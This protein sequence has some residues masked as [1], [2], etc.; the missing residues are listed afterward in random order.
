MLWMCTT[1]FD[2]QEQKRLI[3]QEYLSHQEVAAMTEAKET[4]EES[5]EPISDT[6][7]NDVQ[8]QDRES[9]LLSRTTTVDFEGIEAIDHDEDDDDDTSL[10]LPDTQHRVSS[11]KRKRSKLLDGYVLGSQ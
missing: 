11:R 7:E 2:L 1:R 9:L 10:P 3:L 4:R 5:F 8:P 6:E